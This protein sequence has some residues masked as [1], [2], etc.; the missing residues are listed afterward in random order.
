MFP[1][2]WGLDLSQE[3]TLAKARKHLQDVTQQKKNL[4]TEITT[5]RESMVESSD[6]DVEIISFRRVGGE[7]EE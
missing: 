7:A 4:E 1:S 3:A 5:L 2:R 6:D